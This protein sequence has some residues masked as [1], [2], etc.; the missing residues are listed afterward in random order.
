M[1]INI[2]IWFSPVVAKLQRIVDH[3]VWE[4]MFLH[5]AFFFFAFIFSQDNLFSWSFLASQ[6]WVFHLTFEKNCCIMQLFSQKNLVGSIVYHI[7]LSI[8]L[9]MSSY[10][11]WSSFGK[12]IIQFTLIKPLTTAFWMFSLHVPWLLLSSLRA[13]MITESWK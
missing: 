6:F 2:L 7:F 10:C 3:N 11:S 1:R 12:V 9:L 5:Q 13:R 4:M 8:N